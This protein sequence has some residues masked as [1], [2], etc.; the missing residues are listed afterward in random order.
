MRATLRSISPSTTKV[1]VEMASVGDER[2]QAQ[3]IKSLLVGADS[4]G[5]FFPPPRFFFSDPTR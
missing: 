4:R 2:F 1:H 3:M 5:A